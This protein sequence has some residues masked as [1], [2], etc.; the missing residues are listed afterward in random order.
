MFS[1]ATL[2]LRLGGMQVVFLF[3]AIE[4]RDRY[5]SCCIV[6]SYIAIV[7]C[8]IHICRHYICTCLIILPHDVSICLCYLNIFWD[9]LK[10]ITWSDQDPVRFHQNQ[11][12][13]INLDDRDLHSAPL[14]VG[15]SSNAGPIPLQNQ[16]LRQEPLRGRTQDDS[17]ETNACA[18]LTLIR[19]VM[20][21]IDLPSVKKSS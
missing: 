18:F 20:L 21:K 8:C 14:I 16:E 10:S 19:R 15:V 9:H 5:F 11:D 13:N 12:L 1:S 4:N 2:G 7:S 6:I 17:E 3:L